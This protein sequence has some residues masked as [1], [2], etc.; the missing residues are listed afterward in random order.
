[1]AQRFFAASG[2]KGE[3]DLEAFDRMAGLCK[4]FRTE[5]G[6]IMGMITPAW[7]APKWLT[8]VEFA[9]WSE[10][11]KGLHLLRQFERWAQEQGA[12]EVRMT[13]LAALPGAEK[14]LR[15]KGYE[16]AEI[17]WSRFL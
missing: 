16:P 12:H 17:S 7:G 15:R 10:D 5:R 1:M 14:I 13:T 6:F 9:W 3:F 2:L 8:A 11:G 4:V